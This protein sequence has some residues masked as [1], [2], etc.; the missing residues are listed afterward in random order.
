MST[1]VAGIVVAALAVLLVAGSTALACTNLATLALSRASGH[2]GDQITLVGTSFP[3]PR[4]SSST[5][6]TEVVIHWNAA[7]GPVLAIATPDRTGT[8]SVTFTVPESAPGDTILIATQRRPLADPDHPG[9]PPVAYVD[10]VGTPARAAF[11][12]LARG[13]PAPVPPAVDDF[14]GA[15]VEAGP[16]GMILL[17]VLFAAVALSLFFGGVI[18]FLHQVHSRRYYAAMPERLHE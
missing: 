6:A 15:H 14:A 12:V 10:E 4:A 5:P 3:V 1:G 18:A 13:E 2:V 7:D 8:I 17:T 16:T 11:R 9:A